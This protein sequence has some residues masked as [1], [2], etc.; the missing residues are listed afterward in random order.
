MQVALA[1]ALTVL[2]VGITLELGGNP[3]YPIIGWFV[4][5]AVVMVVVGFAAKGICALLPWPWIN[6]RRY[7]SPPRRVHL[8]WRAAVRVPVWL[9]WLCF[10]WFF[11]SLAWEHNDLIWMKWI[12]AA[13]ALAL[14]AG[15]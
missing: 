13:I 6:D 7:E 2:Y 12:I 8:S 4:A 3:S 9:P 10:P 11:L 15:L 5:P 14:L 1:I